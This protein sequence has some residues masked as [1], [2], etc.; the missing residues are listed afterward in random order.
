MRTVHRKQGNEQGAAQ[1]N[2]RIRWAWGTADEARRPQEA[3]GPR[4]TG[5]N[6]ALNV[7]LDRV[8]LLL[9]VPGRLSLLSVLARRPSAHDDGEEGVGKDVAQQK[10]P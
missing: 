7:R 3:K 5:H 1:L 8:P 10:L 9:A 4:S 2:M 6:E